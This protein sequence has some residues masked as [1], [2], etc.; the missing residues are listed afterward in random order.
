M[1]TSGQRS[2]AAPAPTSSSGM[3]KPLPVPHPVNHPKGDPNQPIG[4]PMRSSNNK[5]MMIDRTP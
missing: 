5:M 1:S 4:L 2:R 3:Y